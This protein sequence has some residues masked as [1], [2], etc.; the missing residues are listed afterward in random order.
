MPFQ[1][2]SNN[3]QLICYKNYILIAIVLLNILYYDTKKCSNILETKLNY[4]IYF[5]NIV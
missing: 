5:D 4:F 1:V 2:I 3:K